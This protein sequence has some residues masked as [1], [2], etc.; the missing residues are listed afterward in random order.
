MEIENQKL[1]KWFT[2]VI[3]KKKKETNRTQQT[4]LFL[5]SILVKPPSPNHCISGRNEI[6]LPLLFSSLYRA[7]ELNTPCRKFHEEL[8]NGLSRKE[9]EIR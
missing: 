9:V 1:L 3:K 5:P 7:P 6:N 8:E 2:V 4:F